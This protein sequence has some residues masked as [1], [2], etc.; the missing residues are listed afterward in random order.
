MKNYK[1]FIGLFLVFALLLAVALGCASKKKYTAQTPALII[2]GGND[3]VSFSYIVNG[4]NYQASSKTKYAVMS[5]T[6]GKACYIPSE[7]EKAYFA[8]SNETCGQ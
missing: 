5:G 8:Y 7:P 6:T 2:R 4:K 3:E 1:N